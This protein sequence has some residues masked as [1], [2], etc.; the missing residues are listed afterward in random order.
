[1][2]SLD[3]FLGNAARDATPE[4]RQRLHEIV[5]PRLRGQYLETG[6][7]HEVRYAVADVMGWTV[8]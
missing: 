2:D 8:D 1:M 7:E 5:L 4:Q 6:D 3:R